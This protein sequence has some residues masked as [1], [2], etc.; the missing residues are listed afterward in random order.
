MSNLVEVK[1]HENIAEVALNRPEAY[2]AFNLDMI[3]ELAKHPTTLATDDSVKGIT[4][5]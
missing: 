1:Q 5:T 4:L 3:P 2:N